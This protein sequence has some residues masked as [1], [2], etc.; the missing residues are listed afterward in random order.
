[1]SGRGVT[2]G[3][4][5]SAVAA[6]ALD[7]TEICAFFRPLSSLAVVFAILATGCAA[8]RVDVEKVPVGTEVEV[9][10]QDGGVVRGTLAARDDETVRI[11]AGSTSRSVPRDQIAVVQ[12][13][14]EA[15]VTPLPPIATFREFTLPPGTSLAVR[16]ESAVGS[17]SSRVEDRIEATLMEA[18]FVDGTEVLPSGS[19]V[20]GEIA[21]AEAAGKV[22]GRASLALRFSSI[23]VAGRGEQYPMA[24]HVNLRAPATK[25]EDA[26]KIGI[27]AAGGAIIGGLI[28]GKKGAAIGTAVGGGAGTAV[29][30]STSGHEVRLATGSTLSL[31][32]DDAVD[33]RVP[34]DKS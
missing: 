20:H 25:G 22:K 9:T 29:V 7:M 34:I 13:V 2:N 4:A 27:P 23:S 21:A 10:R 24:A 5:A 12:V 16:L 8:D 32:L 18:V 31:R 19:V 17:D 33:I 14:D 3:T 6:Y 1:M 15:T 11:K 30:L 26:A 28:G